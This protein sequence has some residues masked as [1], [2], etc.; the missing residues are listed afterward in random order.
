MPAQGMALILGDNLG[1]DQHEEAQ[2]T[3]PHRSRDV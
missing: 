1:T 3:V 2:P